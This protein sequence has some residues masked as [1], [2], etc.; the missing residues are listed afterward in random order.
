MADGEGTTRKYELR[1]RAD[2][3]NETRRRITDAAIELHAKVGPARTTIV[4]IAARAGVQ[5]HTV[6][7]YFPT[8]EE[9]LQACSTEYW[10]RHPWPAIAAWQAVA[11]PRERVIVALKDLYDFYG[12][13]EPMLANSLR[14]SDQRA[15][16][17]QVVEPFA[18]YLD[19][20]TEALTADYSPTPADRV[21][22]EA[23][24]RH[25][26]DFST[27]QSLVRSI[28]LDV[29]AAA[30]LMSSLIDSAAAPVAQRPRR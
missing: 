16:V 27:W 1:R 3:M 4:D 11:S 17:K 9:L 28:G 18:A 2:A 12:A 19:A 10:Q 20:V 8:E 21:L 14:D 15:S 7:R 13:V 29:T 5:R 23:A 26:T 24:I 22:F 25:A 30:E 6:Y